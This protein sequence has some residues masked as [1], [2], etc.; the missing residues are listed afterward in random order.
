MIISPVFNF[1]ESQ[2]FSYDGGCCSIRVNKL[3]KNQPEQF[4][5]KTKIYENR[6]DT[7]VII[8][9]IL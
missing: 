3:L 7:F 1:R 4:D 6:L 2:E 8:S 5:D 9:N